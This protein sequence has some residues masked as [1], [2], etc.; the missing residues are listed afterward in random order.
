MVLLLL[1]SSAQRLGLTGT[2]YQS[3]NGGETFL[4]S[5]L[6][7]FRVRQRVLLP[8]AAFRLALRRS[9]VNLDSVVTEHG[10]EPPRVG[11]FG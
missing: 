6:C 2:E 7:C 1:F 3:G 11:V 10:A 9:S 8:G 4:A 5:R